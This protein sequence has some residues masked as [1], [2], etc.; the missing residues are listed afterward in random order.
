MLDVS[1]CVAFARTKAFHCD[2]ASI[3]H[4]PFC[5]VDSCLQC[6]FCVLTDSFVSRKGRQAHTV[7]V[8]H[9]TF[10]INSRHR[11]SEST[12]KCGGMRMCV[13]EEH[14]WIGDSD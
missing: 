7:L 5:L 3:A 12:D 14:T 2:E 4:A 8:R 11:C 1:T 6:P 10:R 13:V 9:V